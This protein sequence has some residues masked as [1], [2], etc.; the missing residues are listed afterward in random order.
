MPIALTTQKIAGI[1]VSNSLM[2]FMGLPVTATHHKSGAVLPSSCGCSQIALKGGPVAARGSRAGGEITTST[3][4]F[5]WVLLAEQGGGPPATQ[6]TLESRK[7]SDVGAVAPGRLAARCGGAQPRA[8]LAGH[9]VVLSD[10]AG[11]AP[12]SSRFG[13][14]VVPTQR[15][16]G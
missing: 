8:T 1:A 13:D 5:S 11:S 7:G 6:R 14:R 10:E 9:S 2:P 16:L 3:T 15:V 12:V 4:G